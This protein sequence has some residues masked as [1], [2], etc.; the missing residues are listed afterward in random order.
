[1]LDAGLT[2]RGWGGF[3]RLSIHVYVFHSCMALGDLLVSRLVSEVADLLPS[4]W[5]L[6]LR[7]RD[8]IKVGH[9]SRIT[10]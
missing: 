8:D 9:C 10:V 4:L 7:S 6:C 5:E 3:T 2:F 1:M